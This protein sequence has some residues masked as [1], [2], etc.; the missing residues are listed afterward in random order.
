MANAENRIAGDCVRLS[1]WQPWAALTVMSLGLNFVWEMLQA[2]LY[3]DMLTM[4]RW[5]ATWL[6]ARASAGD[7]VITLAA[8]GGVAIAARS[9]AWIL[10]SRA[11]HVGGYV[12]IGLVVTIALE[13]VNVYAL[14]RWSYAPGMPRVLGVGLAP[15]AQWLI[16]PML[17]LW[18]IRRHL[19]RKAIPHSPSRET[20]P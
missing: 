3:K 20:S 5:E 9:R 4:P 7:A 16:V 14:E 12:T 2:P 19:H 6:C 18:G 15:M 17:I 10:D 8:Y 1:A 11:R 13:L